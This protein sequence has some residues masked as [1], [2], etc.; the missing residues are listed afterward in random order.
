VWYA[1]AAAILLV[2]AA[3]VVVLAARGGTDERQPPPPESGVVRLGSPA[4]PNLPPLQ[5]PV[6]RSD[7]TT[8]V[9]S[10][11]GLDRQGDRLV[12]HVRVQDGA[13][14]TVLDLGQGESGEAYGVGVRVV[15][16]WSMPDSRHD[17]IDVSV[18]V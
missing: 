5:H 12:G 15:Q 18:T 4:R 6:R 9:L 3:V 10:M 16:L 17:A 14:A 11:S 7:G 13:R 2:A 1:A 8:A